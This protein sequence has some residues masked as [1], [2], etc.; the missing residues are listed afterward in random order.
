MIY[1]STALRLKITT[2]TCS[3][4]ILLDLG[5]ITD[6]LQPQQQLSARDHD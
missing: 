1:D 2:G 4:Q 6:S 3:W 5:M